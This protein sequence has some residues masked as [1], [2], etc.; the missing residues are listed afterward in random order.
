MNDQ[1]FLPRL[2]DSTEDDPLV[3]EVLRAAKGET[4]DPIHVSRALATFE[5]ARRT[6]TE[7]AEIARRGSP[8]GR[9]WSLPAQLGASFAVVCALGVGLAVR[10][11][12]TD[13]R[14]RVSTPASEDSSDTA[15]ARPSTDV[16]TTAPTRVEDLPPA[17]T[18][19]S[20][21]SIA[22]TAAEAGTAKAL[23]ARVPAS[24]QSPASSARAPSSTG[25]SATTFHDELALVE[26]ARSALAR[27]DVERCLELLDRHDER[28]PG[29]VFS[30]EIVVMRIEALVARGDRRRAQSL[31]E[32][33]LAKSPDSAYASRIRS[34]L[35]ISP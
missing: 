22:G 23:P 12:L 4:M 5:A 26:S 19:T 21:T 29:G 24:S 18:S 3:R 17:P 27:G 20:G 35:S 15:P 13:G 28:F 31:G 14:I 1:S 33:F 7:G 11:A 2:S 16:T 25:P 10:G 9:R 32:A 8:S 34:V 30:A 6:S